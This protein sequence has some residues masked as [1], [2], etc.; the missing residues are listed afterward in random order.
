[1]KF[2][3]KVR[4]ITGLTQYGIAK[5]LSISRQVWFNWEKRARRRPL[6]LTT[7]ADLRKLSHLSWNEFGEIFD[8][9]FLGK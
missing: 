5:R 9:E 3:K 6:L 7:L 1:M 8:K 4:D 2:F